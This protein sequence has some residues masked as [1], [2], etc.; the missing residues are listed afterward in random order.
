MKKTKKAFSVLFLSLVI[1]LCGCADKRDIVDTGYLNDIVSSDSEFI[2]RTG[3]ISFSLKNGR[4]VFLDPPAI[5]GLTVTGD[6]A[7]Y[8]DI[9]VSLP[10]NAFFVSDFLKNAIYEF[11][12]DKKTFAPLGDSAEYRGTGYYILIK[13]AVSVKKMT[14]ARNGSEIEYEVLS[15]NKQLNG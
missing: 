6:K 8:K 2:V 14:V 3:D 9:E 11:E 12:S 7:M 1:L 10:E 15:I 5:K 13:D 4:T